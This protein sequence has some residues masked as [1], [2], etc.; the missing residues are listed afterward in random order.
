M[1]WG[2]PP[3]QLLGLKERE[4]TRFNKPSRWIQRLINLELTTYLF[5]SLAYWNLALKFLAASGHLLNCDVKLEME[6]VKTPSTSQS[7]TLWHER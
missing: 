1:T 4:Q 7:Y 3:S 5:E 6:A 2:S